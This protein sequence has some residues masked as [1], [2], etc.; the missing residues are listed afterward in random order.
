MRRPVLDQ[1]IK[2]DDFNKTLQLAKPALSRVDFIPALC[3]F[4]VTEAEVTAFNGCLGITVNRG[5]SKPCLIPGDLSL[6][7]VGSITNKRA[8]LALKQNAM[9]I[10]AGKSKIELPTMDVDEFVL[11]LPKGKTKSAITVSQELPE[12]SE[13]GL[14]AAG[15][16]ATFP[17]LLGVSLFNV[18]GNIT[19]FA[20]DNYFLSRYDTKVKVGKHD[21]LPVVLPTDFCTSLISLVNEFDPTCSNTTI[22]VIGTSVVCTVGTAATVFTQCPSI[23]SLP[24]FEE[25]SASMLQ[26]TGTYIDIPKA[27]PDILNRSCMLVSVDTS[28]SMRIDAEKKS[29]Q[30]FTE[31]AHGRAEETCAVSEKV[32]E[33]S[34]EVDPTLL[35]KVIATAASICF[36]ENVVAV[37][38]G[39][40][41]VYLISLLEE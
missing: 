9:H 4:K 33:F 25:A 29:L 39:K 19:V 40:Q 35:N 5:F 20:S 13:K 17:E 7:M 15:L 21:K 10:V 24:P 34:V 6:R 41:H 37:K 8:T 28:P 16:D 22:S 32:G 31:T 18:D 27:L 12:G 2:L 26:G 36:H 11:D 23:K 3:N 14:I 38:T 30:F 1:G